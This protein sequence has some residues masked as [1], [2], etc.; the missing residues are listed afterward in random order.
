LAAGAGSACS[1]LWSTREVRTT[2]THTQG[3]SSVGG[4]R[5]PW[6]RN[7]GDWTNGQGPTRDWT[8]TGS[9]WVSPGRGYIPPHYWVDFG[10]QVLNG[11]PQCCSEKHCRGLMFLL[12]TP[13]NLRDGMSG[14]SQW[15]A[16][17]W[18]WSEE[19]NLFSLS[20]QILCHPM[21]FAATVKILDPETAWAGMFTGWCSS[22]CTLRLH[23][24]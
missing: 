11:A 21:D 7:P 1:V 13:L 10:F 5:I 17:S 12:S 20:Q 2:H 22:L 14:F 15:A 23:W 4:P 18:G 16:F 24:E 3:R 19:E 8:H 6:A 9:S